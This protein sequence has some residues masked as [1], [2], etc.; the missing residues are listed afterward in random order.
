MSVL[1]TNNARAQ[2]YYYVFVE[3]CD[4]IPTLVHNN[5]LFYKYVIFIILLLHNTFIK[6]V[7]RHTV[8]WN[9][10]H[11]FKIL[12]YPISEIQITFLS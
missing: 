7:L 5:S 2:K 11:L 3:K 12:L 10:F 6:L 1:R 4:F 8:P 9:F